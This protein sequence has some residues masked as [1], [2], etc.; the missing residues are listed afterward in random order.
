MIVVVIAATVTTAQTVRATRRPTFNDTVLVC[1][2][3]TRRYSQENC[4]IARHYELLLAIPWRVLHVV[5][6]VHHR[7]R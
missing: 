5:K 1:E 2:C 3:V 6:V 4:P 7:G